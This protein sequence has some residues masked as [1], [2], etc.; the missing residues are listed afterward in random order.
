MNKFTII[1]LIC[2]FS[3]F[4]SIGLAQV[5]TPS[6]TPSP[7]PAPPVPTETCLTCISNFEAA[8]PN[9]I[10]TLNGTTKFADCAELCEKVD[11]Q[12][13][14]I[15]N[16]TCYASG[17][18]TAYSKIIE[19]ADPIH[20]C[21]ISKLCPV[22]SRPSAYTTQVNNF[23]DKP[24]YGDT[25]LF[26][27]LVY[28]TQTLGVGEYQFNITDKN[29]TVVVTNTTIIVNCE[30]GT[31]VPFQMAIPTI[32]SNLV[33][34]YTYSISSQICAGSCNSVKF[35]EGSANL[36]TIIFPFTIAPAS[37]TIDQEPEV[38]VVRNYNRKY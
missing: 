33:G 38:V 20:F 21:L 29:G 3:L 35:Y 1:S 16:T 32:G 27:N 2:I 37:S 12:S 17:N 9:I 26:K 15:C 28:I 19:N 5:G 22:N 30:S 31:Y 10:E 36:G 14:T 7:T 4:I 25:I 6:P 18:I 23:P 34:N 13:F 11:T 8:A 24:K